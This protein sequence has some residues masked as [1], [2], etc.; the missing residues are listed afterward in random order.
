LSIVD[1]TVAPLEDS[2][3]LL[4]SGDKLA[5]VPWAVG[6]NFKAFSTFE[7]FHNLSFI[8]LSRIVKNDSFSIFLPLLIQFSKVNSIFI[9]LYMKIKQIYP[10][11]NLMFWVILILNPIHL[12]LIEV[13]PNWMMSKDLRRYIL[14]YF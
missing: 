14:P 12:V 5:F 3:S 2:S 9:F 7:I 6:V 13:L 4:Y 8:Y 10:F 11:E 1:L